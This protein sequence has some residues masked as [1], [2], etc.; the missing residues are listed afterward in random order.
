LPGTLSHSPANILRRA[1]VQLGH[2]ADPPTGPWP[3]YC[4]VEPDRPDNVLTV[5]DTAGTDDGRTMIDGARQGFRGVQVRVRASDNLVGSAKAEALA[6]ALDQ[7]YDVLVTMGTTSYR[8]HAVTRTSDPLALGTDTPRS[9]RWL[10]TVNARF[11]VRQ[12][13]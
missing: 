9:R 12:T 10:F 11:T 2:G 3:C 4:P 13:S 5:Q 1:L 6:V 7:L 8:L